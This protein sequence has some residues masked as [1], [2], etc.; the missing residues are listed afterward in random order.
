MGVA[1][2][3]PDVS[4]KQPKLLPCGQWNHHKFEPTRADI[5]ASG[6]TS[7]EQKCKF[8][9]QTRI[10][11]LKPHEVAAVGAEDESA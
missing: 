7:A 10:L 6:Q 4:K 11:V 8:C 1:P 2:E 5:R 9:A 3:E